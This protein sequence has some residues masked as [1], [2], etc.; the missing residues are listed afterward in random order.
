MLLKPGM[1]LKLIAS[2]VLAALVQPAG[3]FQIRRVGT[4]AGVVL[5][6][7]GDVRAGDYDHLKA[8]LQ[9]GSVA[10][11]EIR[12]GGGSLQDGFDIARVVRD[13]GIIVYASKECDSVCAFILFAAKQRYI[14]RSGKIG[15]HS[16]ANY[17]G[18]EDA[19][20]ARLT[21]QLSRL[22]AGLGVPHSVIG[23]L[24]AT[25][26]GRI[27]FLD[28]RDLAGL[29]VHR[30]NPF[31][32][33]YDAARVAHSQQAGSVC[34]AGVDVETRNDGRRRTKVLQATGARL[35]RAVT[36]GSPSSQWSAGFGSRLR[37]RPNRRRIGKAV[38][39]V[40][41]APEDSRRDRQ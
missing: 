1:I 24:V 39:A 36:K 5:K 26:P 7:R 28:N 40:R 10:G 22:L 31:R 34:N 4:G 16:V 12:S 19:D 20:T 23:K 15:V 11:L 9:S 2:V 18:K 41:N 38:R 37:M 6:L 25:P 14:G 13:K 3:A 8:I 32:N 33:I 30:T 21:V 27:T 29:N 35:R 17:R